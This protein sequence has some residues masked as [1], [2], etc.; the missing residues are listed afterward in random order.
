MQK[1]WTW[2][3]RVLVIVAL[4]CAAVAQEAQP[5]PSAAPKETAVRHIDAALDA[6]APLRTFHLAHLNTPAQ[7]QDLVNALRTTIALQRVQALPEQHAIVVRA[8]DDQMALAAKLIADV[9]QAQPQARGP[10]GGGST[11][12]LAFVLNE[13]ENGK[14]VNSRSYS[15]LALED[16]R[17]QFRVG[18]RVPVATG[19][20]SGGSSS[21]VNTQFQYLDVGVNIDCRVTGTEDNLALDGT[22][23]VSQISMP[24]QSPG[25]L[26]QPV[27]RQ[28][29]T[30]FGAGVPVGKQTLLATLDEVDAPRHMEIEVTATKVK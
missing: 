29:K 19:S 8:H 9:D 6:N 20:V 14:K 27:I 10:A 4:G 23:E 3:L 1:P 30:A 24:S 16:R 21:T 26:N 17:G 2:A 28:S 7:F 15:M 18:S 22:V 12:K 5:A 13:F 25:A 11:Y